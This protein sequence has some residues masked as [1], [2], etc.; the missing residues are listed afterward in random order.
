MS[1]F[2]ITE[3]SIAAAL[4]RLPPDRWPQ[5]LAFIDSLLPTITAPHA[6]TTARNWSATQLR[7]LP[8]AER[9]GVLAE[10]AAAIAD[11]YRNDPDLTAFEAFGA[12]D[13][14]VDNSDTHAR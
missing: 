11:E 6:G 13:I 12:D 1:N 5:V 9:D 4:H 3:Q 14:Y 2:P 10:Q 7:N 8:P